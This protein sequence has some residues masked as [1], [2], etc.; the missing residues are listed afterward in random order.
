MFTNYRIS[1]D[2]IRSVLNSETLKLS[3][4]MAVLTSV[5]PMF[6]VYT[7]QDMKSWCTADMESEVQRFKRRQ[8]FRE[9]SRD[10]L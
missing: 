5:Q 1:I 2:S 3:P 9:T 6:K 7:N 4:K 10:S 8:F